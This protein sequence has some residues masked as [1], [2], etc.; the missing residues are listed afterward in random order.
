M[1]NTRWLCILIAMVGGLCNGF[2][3]DSR[4]NKTVPRDMPSGA[5][6]AVSESLPVTSDACMELRHDAYMHNGRLWRVTRYR[7]MPRQNLGRDFAD[8]TPVCN[9]RPERFY[10]AEEANATGVR[11]VAERLF[12]LDRKRQKRFLW[13]RSVWVWQE[14]QPGTDLFL[15]EKNLLRG[16]YTA[17]GWTFE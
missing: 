1:E 12:W 6:L 14:L 11:M 2:S 5:S 8:S 17:A 7:I 3:A 15:K 4:W 10:A 13:M 9:W 16:A